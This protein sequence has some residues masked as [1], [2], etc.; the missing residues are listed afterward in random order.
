MPLLRT[1][2]RDRVTVV[3]LD[4][5]ARRNAISLAMADELTASFG[6]LERAA[7]PCP[8][9]VTGVPPA[10]SAGAD[11]SD[12]E[13]ATPASLRRIYEGFLAVARYPL[14]TIAAVN[15]PAVGAGL[16][17]ALA[18]DVR[19]AARGA[20]FESRFLDLCLHPGG[21]HTWM[22]SRILG[23][24]GAAA[25]VLLGESLDGE[26]AAR[27]G[28]AWSCVEDAQLMDEAR[29]IAGRATGASTALQRRLKATLR[30]MRT[31]ASHEEAVEHEL[32]AQ[33]WSMEQ[34]AF[35]E[36]LAGLKQRIADKRPGGRSRAEGTAKRSGG[37]S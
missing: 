20:R 13:N 11:L 12:L 2:T 14:P 22:L 18:C 37:D 26:A 24:Q 33:V 32:E 21:G 19:V 30:G 35:R 6:E 7:E 3:T 28:L 25:V 34:P 17:L 9:I 1:E 10:F 29:R 36:R 16:N 8:V 15:G 27:R 4:D 5:P 31:V 23:P